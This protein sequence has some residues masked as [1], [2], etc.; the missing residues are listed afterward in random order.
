MN[1]LSISLF[2]WQTVTLVLLFT[3]IYYIIKLYRKLMKYLDQ[4]KER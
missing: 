4:K 3:V 2:I 1:D